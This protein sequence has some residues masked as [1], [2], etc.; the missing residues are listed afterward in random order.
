PTYD[1]CICCHVEFGVDDYYEDTLV[2]YR[3]QWLKKGAKWA[4]KKLCPPN[5]NLKEQ[6]ENIMSSEEAEQ[7][8]EHYLSDNESHKET[9]THNMERIMRKRNKADKSD[10]F[11]YHRKVS[12]LLSQLPKP[13]QTELILSF[14]RHA[15]KL[16][17]EDPLQD[18]FNMIVQY[19]DGHVSISEIEEEVWNVAD[20][21][22]VKYA[23]SDQYNVYL[24][25]P[26]TLPKY[27][28]GKY[29][30]IVCDV[31]P[32]CCY[33]EWKAN[34][35][36]HIILKRRVNVSQ[37]ARSSCYVKAFSKVGDDWDSPDPSI[38]QTARKKGHEIS[39]QEAMW[40]IQQ[41][42]DKLQIL[43]ES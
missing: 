8:L 24:I 38:R 32:Y 37:I 25:A 5:W 35:L 14:V 7:L 22:K 29:D 36:M 42:N 9:S 33:D 3:I 17:D 34:D 16:F 43:K 1:Y 23:E 2:E 41:I 26:P 4:E 10:E 39:Q 31:Y 28:Q 15:F 12:E 40:Q 6:L 13:A 18:F 19:V 11:N 20:W 21:K 30:L 27:L